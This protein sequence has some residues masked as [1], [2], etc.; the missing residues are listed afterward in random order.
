ME[1]IQV[2]TSEFEGENTVYVLGAESDDELTLVDTGTRDPGVRRQIERGLERVGRSITAVDHVFLTHYHEDHIGLAGDIQAASGAT[3]H[4]PVGDAALIEGDT[5]A[6]RTLEEAV[7]DRFTT[8]GMPDAKRSETL[9][10]MVTLDQDRSHSPV[11]DPFEPGVRFPFDWGTLET[12]DLPGHTAGHA[13]FVHQHRDGT[14][15]YSGDALL[16]VYTPNVGGADV[17]TDDALATYVRTLDRIAAADYSRALPGHR[18]PIE[19]PTAR[20]R[21]IRDHH[22]D[23]TRRVLDVLAD[24]GL[25]TTWEVSAALFGELDGIHIL[26]GPGE[27]GAHLEHLHAHD[28]V[29]RVDDRYRRLDPTP[30]VE[31]LFA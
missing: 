18:H 13:G 25:Y 31:A 24:D 27:A 2:E 19:E 16:P 8:W 11:V 30:D 14:D 17:R 20:A 26:H 4:A 29:E 15:L 9:E 7:H 23:R 10:A 1:R 22:V 6:W 12:I 3:V 28:A 21:E 5:T